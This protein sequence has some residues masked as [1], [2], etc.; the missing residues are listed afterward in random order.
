[1]AASPIQ[2]G[3]SVAVITVVDEA[4][5]LFRAAIGNPQPK[6]RDGWHWTVAE[7]PA[8]DGGVHVVVEAQAPERSHLPAQAFATRMLQSWRPRTLIIADC[9]GGI[10]GADPDRARDGLELG[11]VVISDFIKYYELQ[12]LRDGQRI[13]RD[14]RWLA[15]SMRLSATARDLD[16]IQPRWRD[17]LQVAR[18]GVPHLL[19][20]QLVCGDKLLADEAS[21]EVQHIVETYDKALAVDMETVG[22]AV[23]AMD[24]VDDGHSLSWVAL[25]GISDWIDRPDNQETRD[26]WKPAA[27]DAAVS[28]AL[29]VIAATPAEVAGATPEEAEAVD[30]LHRR[31]D[32]DFTVPSEAFP[33]TVRGPFGTAT[34]NDVVTH[35]ARRHGIALIGSAGV[36]KS[37]VLHQAALAST[38]PLEPF[39]LLIDL[40]SWQAEDSGDL[41]KN[42]TGDALLPSMDVLLRASLQRLGVELL[43]LIVAR[44][45]VLL[46]VDG[47]NEVPYGD[48]AYPILKLL[49]EYMRK[50]PRARV[51]VTD[52]E[53]RSFYDT[54]GWETLRLEPLAIEAVRQ[55][56][57]ERFGRGAADKLESA[58]ELLRIPFF[59][60]RALQGDRID[61]ASRASVLASFFTD[62]LRLT[63]E[64]LDALAA[65]AFAT[66]VEALQRTFTIEDITNAIGGE[67][68]DQLRVAEAVRGDDE[69][70]VFGHQLE[71]D[72]LAARHL[73][74]DPDLWTP[75]TFDQVTFEASSF[76]APAMALETIA[77]EADRDRF[78]RALYNWN[79]RGTITAM[80][81]VEREG[82]PSASPDLRAAILALAAEKRFDAIEGSRTRAEAQLARFEDSLAATF[83]GLPDVAALIAAVAAIESSAPWFSEWQQLFCRPL[84]IAPTA[85]E[86]ALLASSDALLGWTAANVVRRLPASSEAIA[87]IGALYDRSLSERPDDQPIRWRAVHALGAWPTSASAEPLLR[88][89]GDSSNWVV[90]G[91]VRSL[92]EIAAATDDPA[93]RDHIVEQLRQEAS[94]LPSEALGEIA[95][96]ALHRDGTPAFVAAIRPLLMSILNA[97]SGGDRERWQSRIDTF[98][99]HWSRE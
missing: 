3:C 55:R 33:S 47:I 75:E 8:A 72:Y 48:V 39:P 64:Q 85:A 45:D 43:Q 59:L 51:L 82:R 42:P 62:H 96:A 28:A 7:L 74:A 71:H 58:I 32:N 53:A 40:R 65:M 24:A 86:V 60:E 23:A 84:D 14:L 37:T 67:L 17:R 41:A 78:V 77:Q 10:W 44:R 99:Q 16:A 13:P 46:F 90:Y 79:W 6:E 15:P 22:V 9:G 63:D 87:A 66:Y 56:L 49:H 89:L 34:R 68:V 98:D 31:L 12:K 95:Q 97:Q 92:V 94:E 57:D 76:D 4:H 27:C 52:R 73:M 61:N 2:Y 54:S 69:H 20:G 36:G 19:A 80:E 21:D 5:Q 35:V 50:F 83:H 18:D 1:M 29:A 25:R 11:D 88:A 70:L 38:S 26:D 91:A 30:E 93:L 81:W